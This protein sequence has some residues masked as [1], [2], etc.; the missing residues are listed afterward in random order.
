MKK[1]PAPKPKTEFEKCKSP[2]IWS[3][4]KLTLTRSR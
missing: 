2:V 1:M 3:D 4:A